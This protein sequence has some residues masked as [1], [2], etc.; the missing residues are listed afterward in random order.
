MAAKNRYRLSLSVFYFLSGIC[1]STWASRIASIQQNFDLNDAEIGSVLLAMPI[2]SLAGLPFSGFLVSRFDSRIPLTV[3][4]ILL[5][6]ALTMIGF[7][8]NI[9]LLVASICFFSFVLRILNISMNTQSITVQKLFEKKINGSFHGLW[10]T[11]GIIALGFSTLMVVYKVPVHYHFLAVALITLVSTLIFYRNLIKNDRSTSG[12]KLV[13]AKPDPY[14]V[15]L[16]LLVFLAA[17]CEGGMFDW[18]GIY[19][20]KVVQEETFTLGHFM[21]MTSMAVSR[22]ASDKVIERIGM[23]KTYILSSILIFTGIAMAVIY[24]T[25]WVSMFGFCLV[26][27]GAASVFPMTLL[28]ASESKKYSPGTAI[29]II[30]TYTIVGMFIGP[31][32]IGY[33]SH[34]FDLRISFIVFALAGFLLIPISQMFFRHKQKIS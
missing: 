32:M 23:P 34:A 25:F 14:I 33:I 8:S 20:L 10:S 27:L 17:I 22:F 26:G 15:Y 21:F 1:F 18:A 11:G 19:F 28:L 3:A 9:Y 13:L 31:P 30:A 7:A 16:G 24:P 6:V 2:A 4:F 29:S 5:S 12:N